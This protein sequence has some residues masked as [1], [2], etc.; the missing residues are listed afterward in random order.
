MMPCENAKLSN[1]VIILHMSLP[2]KHVE[3]YQESLKEKRNENWAKIP[4]MEK[5][6][7][8]FEVL[9]QLDTNSK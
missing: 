6:V 5:Q 3:I 9:R 7:K 4:S 8:D 2:K 1:D